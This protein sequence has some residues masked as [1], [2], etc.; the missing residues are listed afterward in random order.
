MLGI[1]PDFSPAQAAS[2]LLID[3]L[4]S[5]GHVLMHALIRGT[6]QVLLSL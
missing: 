2:K 3:R 4:N 6:P 5:S 1:V